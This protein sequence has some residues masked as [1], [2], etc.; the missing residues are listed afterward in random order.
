MGKYS[1]F[2]SSVEQQAAQPDTYLEIDKPLPQQTQPDPQA[3]AAPEPE[4]RSVLKDAAGLWGVGTGSLVKGLGWLFNSDELTN[5]GQST[6]DY[7]QNTLSQTQKDAN[8]KRFWTEDGLGEGATDLNTIFGT[9]VQSLPQMIPGMGVAAGLGRGALAL[10]LSQKAAST[11]AATGGVAGEGVTIGAMVGQEVDES[12]RGMTEEEK[13]QSPYYQDLRKLYD[14]EEATSRLS[15]M[16]ANPAALKSGVAGAALGVAFNK[17]LG[18]ALTRRLSGG[19]LKEG[20][21]GTVLEAGTELMQSGAESYSRQSAL[22]EYAAVPMS[23][24][25]MVNE[26]IGGMAAGGVMGGTVGTLGGL[27]GGRIEEEDEDSGRTAPP[28]QPAQPDPTDRVMRARQQAE[29]AG[30]DPLSATIAGSQALLDEIAGRPEA[31]AFDQP[32]PIGGLLTEAMMADV[33]RRPVEPA[34]DQP[35]ALEPLLAPEPKPAPAG[36]PADTKTPLSKRVAPD[37]PDDYGA[38]VYDQ[39]G[40]TVRKFGDRLGYEASS[41]NFRG[42]AWGRTPE[43]AR[44]KLGQLIQR[45]E[46]VAPVLQNRDRSRPAYVEQMQAIA[47]APDYDRVSVSRDPNTGAPMVFERRTPDAPETEAPSQV[48]VGDLGNTD[49]VTMSDGKGGT[50]KVPV[51]YAVVEADTVTASNNADGSVNDTYGQG[52]LTALN[53]GRTAGLQGAYQKGTAQ[54]YIDG[55]LA[56]KAHGVSPESIRAKKNPMLVRLFDEA[57]LE[58]IADPGAASN[59][60]ANAELS[61]VEQAQTDARKL[62][63]DLLGEIRPGE[64]TGTGNMEF[65]RRV[66]DLLGK[67]GAGNSLR[68]AKGLLT[69]AGQKRIKGALVERAY[70]D[71]T[72][73]QELTEA[74]D[75]DLKTLGDALAEVA[76]RWALMRERAKEGSIN[77]DMDIT[78]ALVSAVNMIRT[79]R[80]QG[81]ALAD[82]AGQIDAFSGPVDQM[83]VEILH[84]FYHGKNFGRIR[85]KDTIAQTLL[86]YVDSALASAPEPDMFGEMTTPQNALEAQRGQIDNRQDPRGLQPDGADDREAG[87]QGERPVSGSGGQADA[88]QGQDS[89]AAQAVEA[90]AAQANTDPTDGQKDAGNYQKGHLTLHGLNISIENPRGSIRSGTDP[91]G[92]RW[93]RELAHH[94]GYIKRTEGADGDQV[95]VF[96]GPNPDSQ[97]V[98]VI[99]QTDAQGNFDEHKV[100]LGFP[101]QVAARRGYL[102]NYEDG[103]KVGPVTAMSM[104]QFKRW[105][106]NGDTTAPVAKDNAV[107]TAPEHRSIG[108]DDRELAQVV[109]EFKDAHEEMRQ[110]GVH[111]LFDHPAKDE[112]VRLQ[113]KARVYHKK[114]GWMTPKEAKARIQEWKQHVAKQGDQHAIDNSNRVVLS[115]FDLT[116]KWSE[117]WEQAGYEVYRFD[118]QDDPEVGDVNNFSTDFFGDWFGDFEGKDIYAIIAAC[119]CTDFASSG[120][121]HFAAKDADGRTVASV[122]L[123]HQTLRVIEY[124]RPALWAVEN[125][126]GRIEKL[127]GLPPWR[128]SFDP[129]HIGDP[130]TKKTL[131][132]GRFNADLPIAPVEPTEGSK[133]H[134]KYGG[135][136]IATKNARSVTPEGFAYGFF[137]ANNAIDNP[138]LAVAN[139]YDRLDRQLFEQAIEVGLTEQQISEVI[140]D[141]YYMDLDDAAAEQALKDLID[142]QTADADG[143]FDLE[144]QTEEQLAEQ[145]RTQEQ[146]QQ[147]EAQQQR[148]AEQREKAD[149]ERDDFVLSGSSRQVDQAEAR[150]QGNMFDVMGRPSEPESDT[151]A[152]S[153]TRRAKAGGEYGLNGEWYKGGQIMPSSAFTVKGQYK[154]EQQGA[155]GTGPSLVAPGEM[156][157]APPGTRA[158]FNRIQQFVDVKDGKLVRNHL[159]DETVNNFFEDVSELEALIE[160][161]NKGALFYNPDSKAGTEADAGREKLI[162]QASKQSADSALSEEQLANA[163]ESPALREGVFKAAGTALGLLEKVS[164]GSSSKRI[165]KAAA[166]LGQP[167]RKAGE[168]AEDRIRRLRKVARDIQEDAYSYAWVLEVN[169]TADQLKAKAKGYSLK[170]TGNKKQIAQSI[171]D[172]IT[173]VG[174]RFT[175][176]QNKEAVRAELLKL[177]DANQPIPMARLEEL[178]GASGLRHGEIYTSNDIPLTDALGLKAIPP[179]GQRGEHSEAY[180]IA[181]RLFTAPLELLTEKGLKDS[182]AYKKLVKRTQEIEVIEDPWWLVSEQMRAIFEGL[183]LPESLSLDAGSA[184]YYEAQSEGRDNQQSVAERADKLLDEVFS[185]DAVREDQSIYAANVTGLDA[186]LENFTMGQPEKAAFLKFLK[187]RKDADAILDRLDTLRDTP[188]AKQAILGALSRQAMNDLVAGTEPNYESPLTRGKKTP[189][190]DA[191]RKFGAEGIWKYLQAKDII[192]HPEKPVNAVNGSFID[193]N[194]SRQCATYCY[195]TRGH[196]NYATS[197]NKS[198]LVSWAVENDPK[199]A[200]KM[201]GR[202]YKATAEYEAK[203]ALRLFDKGDLSEAWAPFVKDLN[204]QGIR[205]QIFSKN[206]DALRQIDP[207]NL[208]MLSI[209]ESNVELAAANPDLKVALVYDGTQAMTDWT[210]KNLDRIAVILPIKQGARTLQSEELARLKQN[211]LAKVRLCPI[212]TG[213]RKLGEWDCLKCDKNGGLGCFHGNVTGKVLEAATKGVDSDQDIARL[214]QEIESEADQLSGAQ[215]AELLGSLDSLLSKIRSGTDTLSAVADPQTAPRADER[216][217][218]SDRGTEQGGDRSDRVEARRSSYRANPDQAELFSTEE[219]DALQKVDPYDNAETRPGTTE[220]QRREGRSA[221]RDLFRQL[222]ARYRRTG[223]LPQEGAGVSLLGAA[224]YKRFKEG[225]PN[226][227]IGQTVKTPQDLAVLAQIY[228]DPR[229]ETFRFIL[230][231]GGEVIGEQAV[232]SRLPSMV[233]FDDNIIP[234]LK[235]AMEAYGADGYYIM[236]NHPSGKANPSM[237]DLNTTKRVAAEVPGFQSH[238]VIDFNQYAVIGATG[239]AEVIEDENLG[240]EDFWADPDTPN[241]LLGFHIKMPSDTAQLAKKLQEPGRAVFVGANNKGQVTLLTSM[242]STLMTD[243]T[244]VDEFRKEGLATLRRL[245]RTSGSGGYGFLLVNTDRDVHRYAHLIQKGV[246]RDVIAPSGASA[247][248]LRLADYPGDAVEFYNT[249]AMR[250]GEQTE[251]YPTD[252][253]VFRRWFGDSKVVDA[254]GNPL[255]VYHGAPDA[256]FV[257]QDGTFRSQEDRFGMGEGQ[258]AHW[259]ARSRRVAATYAD[260]RRAFDYQGAE[261]AVVEAYLKLENPLEIDGKG[262]TWREAQKRGKTSD[263]IEQA[264]EEGRDGVIIRNVRDNYNDWEGGARSTPT[265]T[266]V[267]FSSEQIKSA[268]D[269][270]GDFD[271]ANPDIR[272]SRTGANWKKDP[273]R[274][275]WHS[276]DGQIITDE[277]FTMGGVRTKFFP[278]YASQEHRYKGDNYASGET[279]AEAK[280]KA[281][282]RQAGQDSLFKRDTDTDAQGLTATEA[283]NL[284]NQYMR[285]WKGRPS[286]KVVDSIQQMPKGLREAIREAQAEGDMRAVY[287]QDA[288]HILAPRIPNEQALQEVILHEVVGHYG[289][290]GMLGTELK[291]VLNEVYLKF[292]QSAQA[293]EIIRNYFPN[294]SF[295]PSNNNHRL[296]VAEELLAH[297]AE[298]GKHQK[299]WT[300]VLAAIRDGL[301]KLGFNLKLSETDLLNLLRG[302]QKVVEN[303]GFSRPSDADVN[304]SRIEGGPA[305]NE[306]IS[307]ENLTEKE[308]VHHVGGFLAMEIPYLREEILRLSVEQGGDTASLQARRTLNKLQADLDQHISDA[309]YLAQKYGYRTMQE[310]QA[311]Y[312]EQDLRFSRT[313]TRDIDQFTD[314]TEAQREAF[315]KI[316]PLTATESA[317]EWLAERTSRWQTKLRQ[318]MVDRYAALMDVDEALY[319]KDV[320]ENSTASSSWVLAQMAGAAS[321]ALQTMLTQA[322]IYL[323]PREKVIKLQE[324][325][326]RG[327]NEVLKQL[328]SPGEVD[329]FFGWIAGNRS[330]K[331]QEEG[332]ENLFTPEESEALAT[333][334]TGTTESGESRADLYDRVYEEFQQYQNDILDIADAAGLLRK[335]ME[336]QDAILFLADEQGVRPDLVKRIKKAMKE[337]NTADDEDVRLMADERAGA[338][339]AELQEQLATDM[340]LD[341]FDT[342]YDELTTDQ[343]DLWAD[344]FYVPFYREAERE[345]QVTGPMPTS[346]LARQQAYKRLKG[347]TSNLRD[348]LE[349]TLL[350]FHHLIEASLKNQ[351]AMQALENSEALGIAQTTT[352]SRRDTENSTFVLR[353]GVKHWYN[354]DDP[355]VFKAVTALA[356]PG[357]NSSAMQMMRGFKRLFTNLTTITVQFVTANLLR[358]SIQ[359][360]ATSE[361]SKNFIKNM[362]QGAKAY[363]NPRTQARMLA[364]GGAFSYGHLYGENAEEVKIQLSG[365]LKSARVIN[366]PSM[367]PE[368]IK[369]GWRKWNEA[370]N[371]TENMNRAA[372]FEQNRERKGDLYAAFKARDLM[373]FSQHGAWPAMR[374]L[375]DVVPFL[376]ARLQGLD[377]IYRSGVKPGIRMAMG[378]GGATDKQ[379]MARFWSVTG[380][381]AL[382]TMVLFLRNKDDEEYQKLEE[383]QKDT[384]WFFRIGDQAFFLPKP[385][386]VGAI[387]TLVERLTE[388]AVSDTATGELFAERLGHMLTDTFSFSPVPQMFQPALDVYANYD[389]FT[390]RPIESMG[391]ERLSPS[392]RTRGSTTSIAKGLSKA[393]EAINGPYGKLTLSPVQIDHM[394]Q[395]YFGAVGSWIAG[396][397]DTIWKTANGEVAPDKYWYEYQP[398]KRFYKNLGDEDRYTRYGTL[399][400]EALKETNRVYADIREYQALGDLE[401]A[402]K[403]MEENRQTLALRRTLNRVQRQLT[404]INQAMEKVYRMPGES[405]YKRREL[406]RLRALRNRIQEVVGRRLE[407]LKAS[408]S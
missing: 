19:P 181:E 208:R 272:F 407:Q 153:D 196:Y 383:W 34:F 348:L 312:R 72:I 220:D 54:P 7:W 401:S 106:E 130:Y 71:A 300:R 27:Q 263:V 378:Q 192:G 385:F 406:D 257:Q 204:R 144:T 65:V 259:F 43:E 38:I 9:V 163:K 6:A 269:N 18:D 231:K 222:N 325:S 245:K 248:T 327:L 281:V 290:R 140:D 112:I 330:L 365:Q 399:F 224:I 111:H 233:K 298:T 36:Q 329:R 55:L 78:E 393:T 305:A 352:E 249:K 284:A 63:T 2:F 8:Q 247:A 157:Y 88:E 61:A 310:F 351:A 158:I 402:I 113:D 265:D 227:L 120:S 171:Y 176:G 270:S 218:G 304:F 50:R 313:G 17:F 21:K 92:N 137:M 183:G 173:Q 374:I 116:G 261:P 320:I 98:F 280:A 201:V 119:P 335:G 91:D 189:I 53:N 23:Y 275:I 229:F 346:G 162:Q 197:I 66:T 203:K 364:S 69:A 292:A 212:D 311:A 271:P 30:A 10:G 395:G 283:R 73:T 194:P 139:K 324:G 70:R 384:Y 58:G 225:K 191:I 84:L 59:V 397:G 24:T 357:M 95:D 302:A 215:R 361:V 405:E 250:V 376:N 266:Y 408:S 76:G 133:M 326:E 321:G 211:K 236:H 41:E 221:L 74:V 159:P 168:K 323:D 164:G 350:N 319:G 44:Q 172:F 219:L 369:L 35:Q 125:P 359:A 315:G 11:V 353:D 268:T 28:V 277:S 339:L 341:E 150:G 244:V 238:V 128:L 206:P 83:A 372:I 380:A 306:E 180:E 15:Q 282:D 242:P 294:Q 228:R 214:L 122:N 207:M 33:A 39:D 235:K 178:V 49:T 126:V 108:V 87:P 93:K 195:A 362:F 193:C 117:P 347:G 68:D 328:G 175:A 295:N 90:A 177:A 167:K 240:S 145:A 217:V 104:D 391:M 299:L 387:A 105:L 99:D 1:E 356:H 243:L 102:A 107:G 403:V 337:A 89:E 29:G 392:L 62:D 57:A 381:V 291:P 296:M 160:L 185:Y 371:F 322:R 100:M 276:D 25:D 370:A 51:Q 252:T 223:R 121:R 114:H 12:I 186:V 360:T 331:L 161:Y 166:I 109:E 155:G 307:L 213:T 258:Q 151:K 342:R 336:E 182:E 103:W 96:I 46:T 386:E 216:E 13:M 297:M 234:D 334:N 209:D 394:I 202:E 390:D 138:V 382:A 149:A 264:R 170:A 143:D 345:G 303:G 190:A 45:N 288:I 80:Q 332:R 101:N 366:H 340:G 253:P 363:G 226:R 344:E 82:L 343:R 389:A 230:T 60:S 14:E 4:S 154:Q 241:D 285:D 251:G 388:Q 123:V 32:E 97:Q 404:D 262:K 179:A 136:S 309:L 354:I 152:P 314:L 317:R 188:W 148:E 368:V 81:T 156:G 86:G 131:I 20:A 256:R 184:L 278:V 274:K 165:D 237:A 200:A 379:A 239:V 42:G 198:E 367:V 398:V 301:R 308:A 142:E 26:M 174:K 355:L 400:Y 118:I 64:V 52:G 279:L 255:V 77:P 3:A 318:G 132:W 48:P 254:Q 67:D 338:M 115:L 127:G 396:V 267:V 16:A 210:L 141:P 124:F 110:G 199:R 47:N 147:A 349:N 134:T 85:A 293:K 260:D 205:V 246:V 79:S 375:I 232:T 37:L 146:A 22:E 373:N 31:P 377:K 333:A 316:A 40:V 5:L 129:N 75:N 358:D 56:D 187:G 94:Y 273:Q 135:K 289:L 287:W 169:H 286:V